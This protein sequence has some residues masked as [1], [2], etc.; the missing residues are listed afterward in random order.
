MSVPSVRSSA[1]TNS[2]I[3]FS[4]K[5]YGILNFGRKYSGLVFCSIPLRMVVFFKK[6][7]ER[8]GQ[9]AVNDKDFFKTKNYAVDQG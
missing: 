2:G 7:Q 6:W 5:F 1:R 4:R 3:H 8:K 9:D